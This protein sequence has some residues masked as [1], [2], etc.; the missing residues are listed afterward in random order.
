MTVRVR[1]RREGS[2]DIILDSLR[3]DEE[4]VEEVEEHESEG[5]DEDR[6]APKVGINISS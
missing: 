3:E 5:Q 6:T 2:T 1:V 4:D